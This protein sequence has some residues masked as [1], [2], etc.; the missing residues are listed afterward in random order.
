MDS[1]QFD[2]PQSAPDYPTV[3]LRPGADHRIRRGHLWIFS[4]ELKDG[5]QAL[6]SGAAVRVTDAKGKFWGVGTINPHSLIAVRLFSRTP[7]LLNEPLLRARI[8]AAADLRKRLLG[9]DETVYRLIYSEADGLPGLIV[10]R[11]E[12]VFVIQ[13]NTAGMDR[14]LPIV[15]KILKTEFAPTAIVAA[16]DASVR[17]LEGLKLHRE[18]IFGCLDGVCRFE[19][20]GLQLLA[21]PLKGQKTGFF[22]DQRFNRRMAA[23]LVQSSD[24]VLDL[25][26]YTGA[27]GLYALKAGADQVTFVDASDIALAN[28]REAVKLNGFSD[29]GEFIRAD[30]FDYLKTDTE[31]FDWVLLDPPALAKSRSKVP[32]GLRAYRDL[33]ARAIKKVCPGGFLATSSCSGLV[34]SEHW[35]DALRQAAE[36]AGRRLRFVA[37]G[38]Q[39]P[40]HPILSAMPETQY[41]KFAIAI[42]D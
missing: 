20:D 4:N 8:K 6:P 2:S 13:S 30:I 42:V 1:S 18:V 35:Y 40:D 22:L 23:S 9:N 24:R 16:N 31:Q 25:F 12:S 26:C 3:V 21:D 10:D 7:D 38:T 28:T 33:N 34:A 36:K 14:L 37:H 11:F 27:F 17:E 41:L 29:S 19:Q 39:G 5:F 15:T 32:A